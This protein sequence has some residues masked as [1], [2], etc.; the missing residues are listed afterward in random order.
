M[1]DVSK[2]W[3]RL[4]RLI[5]IAKYSSSKESNETKYCFKY[6]DKPLLPYSQ[7]WKMNNFE[8]IRGPGDQRNYPASI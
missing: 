8:Q 6:P 5:E 7:L 1:T 4:N 3:T 2:S